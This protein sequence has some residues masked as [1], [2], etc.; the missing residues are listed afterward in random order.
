MLR[1]AFAG[2]VLVGEAMI[3]LPFL[4]GWAITGVIYAGVL[5][6]QWLGN[7][8]THTYES[9]LHRRRTLPIGPYALRW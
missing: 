8:F 3:L 5:G 9:K 7:R 4:I 2:L 6:V 1:Y